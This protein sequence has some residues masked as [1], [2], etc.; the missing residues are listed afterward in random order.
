MVGGINS[1]DTFNK[2]TFSRSVITNERSYFAS[3]DI[4]IYIA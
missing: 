3:G 1:G 4:K 2:R